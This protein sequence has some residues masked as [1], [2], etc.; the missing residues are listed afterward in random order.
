MKAYLQQIFEGIGCHLP[1]LRYLWLAVLDLTA[2]RDSPTSAGPDWVQFI[3]MLLSRSQAGRSI[4]H[5]RIGR[6]Y[7]EVTL[8]EKLFLPRVR[9]IV[10]LVECDTVVSDT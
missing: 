10:P 6:L 9:A 1:H 3:R 7:M 5:L 8:A 4:E 2:T